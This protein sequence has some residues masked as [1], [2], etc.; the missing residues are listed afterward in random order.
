MSHIGGNP[1][2]TKEVLIDGLSATSQIQGNVLESSPTMESIQEFSVQTS[3]ISAEYGHTSGGVFNFALKPGTNN[4]HG[5]AYYYGRN[6]ALNANTW[7]NNWQLSQN[8]G[9]QRYERARDRQSVVGG[10]TGGPVIIPGLYDGRNRTF[11]FGTLEHY[12][13]EQAAEL[14]VS[15]G[16]S[17]SSSVSKKT[18]FVVA[19]AS[20]GSKYDRARE[21]GV[22]ILDEKEFKR[23]VSGGMQEQ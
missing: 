17:V 22:R 10:S 16:G 6:E 23:L 4:F 7:M 15:L 12:S 21:L 3:G 1:A 8:P 2:F 13:R 5:S 9:D 19:G 14:V 20:P 18:D 11:I